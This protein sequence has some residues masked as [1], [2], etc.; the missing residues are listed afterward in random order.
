MGLSQPNKGAPARREDGRLVAMRRHPAQGVSPFASTWRRNSPKPS[1]RALLSPA[2]LLF[3]A[4]GRLA[5]RQPLPKHRLAPVMDAGRARLRAIGERLQQIGQLGVAM[6]LHEA[7]HIVSSATATGSQTIGSV[8]SSKLELDQRERRTVG[9]CLLACR[10]RL[11]ETIGDTSSDG[12]L[13]K[14]WIARTR[15]SG[16]SPSETLIGR[17]AA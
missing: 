5:L 14:D 8:G 12:G 2:N 17:G 16:I 15:V 7:R 10:S 3:F 4:P 1:R 13:K 11:I 9:H 6:L